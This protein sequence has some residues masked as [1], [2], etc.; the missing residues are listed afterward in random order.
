RIVPVR[1]HNPC[2]EWCT[3]ARSNAGY[4]RWPPTAGMQNRARDADRTVSTGAGLGCM[5]SSSQR[6]TLREDTAMTGQSVAAASGR[7]LLAGE[8]DPLT[9]ALSI[10]PTLGKTP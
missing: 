3:W 4:E 8:A 7:I 10:R 9:S 5:R 1:R 2:R 6:D